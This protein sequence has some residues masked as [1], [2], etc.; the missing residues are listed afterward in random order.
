LIF[1]NVQSGIGGSYERVEPYIEQD[2]PVLGAIRLMLLPL[3]P[4][5]FAAAFDDLAQHV[6]RHPEIAPHAHREW[7]DLSASVHAAIRRE[8]KIVA[9]SL[10]G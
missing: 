8:V 3:L 1:I 9:R 6:A 10:R 5:E 7:G 4:V 2:A